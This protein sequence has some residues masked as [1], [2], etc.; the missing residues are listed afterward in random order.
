MKLTTEGHPT[1]ETL[2]DAVANL[3]TLYSGMVPGLQ[4]DGI[5]RDADG[6]L[7]EWG[8]PIGADEI[9]DVTALLTEGEIRQALDSAHPGR[10]LFC[11][12]GETYWSVWE[13]DD[14]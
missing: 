7:C 9:E 8:G 11:I 13:V 4:S 14:E 6:N 3:G 2:T 5:Y 1:Y 10:T 12:D